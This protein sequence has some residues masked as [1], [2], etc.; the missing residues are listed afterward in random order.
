MF[1]GIVEE[2]GTVERREGD[3]LIIRA[4]RVLGDLRLGDSVSVNGACLTVCALEGS[5]FTV[6]LSPE[7]LRRTNLGAL[8]PGDPVNLERALAY[9]GRIGGHLVQGHIDATG[10]V[11]SVEP[12]GNSLRVE[13]RPPAGLMR[14]IVEKGF[15]AVDGVSMTVASRTDTTFTLVVIPL[16]Q[17]RTVLGRRRPGDRVN[18]EVDILAKYLESLLASPREPLE[19]ADEL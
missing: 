15:I 4:E 11:L 1:T 10:E 14:Y 18:L 13:V 3:A 8:R 9:G 6:R 7:T 16:T 5:T 2:V 17:E 19:P 12:E